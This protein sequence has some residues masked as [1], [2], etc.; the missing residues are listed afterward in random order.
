MLFLFIFIIA[1]CVLVLIDVKLMPQ[2]DK[3]V[4]AFILYFIMI[5]LGVLGTALQIL[6]IK[7]PDPNE[8]IRMVFESFLI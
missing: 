3:S 2:E 7:I 5:F 8:I 1:F 4:Q 6:S